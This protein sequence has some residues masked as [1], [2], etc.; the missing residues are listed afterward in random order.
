M[1]WLITHHVL[2]N[3]PIHVGQFTQIVGQ[4][5]E[6]KYYIWQILIWYFG[7][8][9]YSEEDLILFNQ[10]EPVISQDSE[11]IKRNAFKII[12]IAEV[13]DIL[14]QISYKK[15]TIG[16]S[17]LS[18]KMQNIE[19]IEELEILNYHLHKIAQKVNSSISLIN[20]EIEYEVGT[21][22]L[23]P[24]QIL[25]KQ[26][27]PHFKKSRD[28]IAIEFISNEKKLCFLLQMLNAIMQE[29]TKPILLVLKNLD[30]Y[31]TYDSFVRIAQY[32]EELSN[33]YPYFN[34]IL[35]PSQE[36]YLYLTEAT[37]ETVNIVSD[38]IEH[39]PAFTFL[40]TRYQQSY[41]STS[42]LGEKEFLNSL[43][44]NSSYLFS[45]DINRVVSLADIDLVTLK[46]V[47]SLYQYDIKMVYMYKGISKLE[48]NYLSS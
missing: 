37:L 31:L 28:E 7:G 11:A 8:K 46:I 13:G 14:E 45:S 2:N 42:P 12:S 23:L 43:R 15:G 38:R 34:T 3:I 48:E 16:F 44:K 20:D 19:I 5:Y 4:N 30:D 39:Y 10:E 22:D 25:T 32:L 36:G 9:K 21:T 17:Y 47:N 33:K 24:E 29:Q 18:L 1:K 41:P 35:F 40:Y 27:T 6:L 26:L